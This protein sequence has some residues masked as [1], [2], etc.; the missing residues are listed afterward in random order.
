MGRRWKGLP[1]WARWFLVLPAALVADTLS[2]SL[3]SG[4][5]GIWEIAQN[6][7]LALRPYIDALIWQAWAPAWFV[8]VGAKVAPSHRFQTSA[9]LA[10]I[11]ILVA[12]YNTFSAVRFV[13]SGG[14]WMAPYPITQAPLWWQVCVYMIAIVAVVAVSILFRNADGERP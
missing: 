10:L 7:R 9:V 13:A 4:S 11:K 8:W 1:T 3:A 12:L 14:S 6:S 5:L 2:Q